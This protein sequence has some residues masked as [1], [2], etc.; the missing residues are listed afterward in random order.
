M[1]R[2]VLIGLSLCGIVSA[3]VFAQ[4]LKIVFSD[5]GEILQHH[6]IDTTDSDFLRSLVDTAELSISQQAAILLARRGDTQITDTIKRRI[7]ESWDE[8][9]LTPKNYV[10]AL[11]LLNDPQTRQYA[12]AVI[13]SI[14]SQ[15][16]RG[17]ARFYTFNVNSCI[18]ILLNLG[19]YSQY[20]LLNSLFN[21]PEGPLG[22]EGIP[23]LAAF[24][25]SPLYRDSVYVRL[26]DFLSSGNHDSRWQAT[27]HLTHF[28]DMANQQSVLQSIASNDLSWDIRILAIDTLMKV[29]HDPHALDAAKTIA[30]AVEDTTAFVNAL[31]RVELFDS[32]L[33]LVTLESIANESTAGYFKDF[34]AHALEFYQPPFPEDDVPIPVMIDSLAANTTQAADLGWLSDAAFRAELISIL[35]TARSSLSNGDSIDCRL[36]IDQYVAAV[37]GEYRDSAD[38]DNRHVDENAW[39]FL[40]YKAQYILNRL[41]TLPSFS[42]YSIF[43]THSGYLEQN[44][45]VLSGDIGINEAGSPPFLNSDVELTIGI[46]TVVSANVVKANRIKIKDGGTVNS[47]VYYNDIENNG[48]ITGQQITPLTLPLVT[49]MPG[50]KPATPGSMNITVPQDGQQV[51]S[52]GAYGDILVRRNGTLTLTGGLY[53]FNSFNT[54]DNARILFQGASEIRIAQK[55]DT[56]QGSYIGPEDTTSMTADQ[57]VFYIG[58]IN[59][60]NGNLTATP[61]AA[62]IGIANTVKANFYVPNG[63]LWIRQN[64]QVTGAFIGK[65]VDVGIGVKVWL[66]SAF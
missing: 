33:A 6:G 21:D 42:Q 45:Q 43:G 39:R 3:S 57:I 1:L 58:G 26:Q 49:S 10:A 46:S 52:S 64:S 34:A 65:D 61:K 11:Y 36:S 60:S 23:T 29:Y 40:F 15:K 12:H 32:P 19:D 66:K 22:S 47:D 14:V 25:A 5:P 53:H 13:D 4:N 17:E 62:Q 28:T 54:G 2:Q 7:S 37:D 24:A 30:L 18:D 27:Y 8:G 50:F 59:G 41:P 16:K 55:L 63:T 31:I 44:S 38:G 9:I 56:D 51:L 20:G 48:T 35:Q